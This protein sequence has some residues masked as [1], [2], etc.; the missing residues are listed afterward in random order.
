MT[1]TASGQPL[2]V[3]AHPSPN[4]VLELYWAEEILRSRLT[5]ADGRETL[6]KRVGGLYRGHVVNCVGHRRPAAS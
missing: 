3:D 4:G 1:T 6:R 5:P 2:A